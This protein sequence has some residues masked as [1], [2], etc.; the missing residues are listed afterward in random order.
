MIHRGFQPKLLTDIALF[1]FNETTRTMFHECRQ[2]M[3]DP[4]TT[5][6]F[7]FDEDTPIDIVESNANPVL[8]NR[9]KLTVIDMT[10]SS[11][12]I[13]R[14][15]VVR[16][17][18]LHY[19]TPYSAFVSREGWERAFANDHPQNL[20]FV[21]MMRGTMSLDEPLRNI[22]HVFSTAGIMFFDDFSQPHEEELRLFALGLD[23]RV[24]DYF[25]A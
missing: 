24:P 17:L 11:A 14:A 9:P 20:A 12:E 13:E 6:V 22:E 25:T 18:A 7:H 23:V 15:D 8:L 3:K 21:G 1:S 2:R 4:S 10:G 16:K 19:G 5:V